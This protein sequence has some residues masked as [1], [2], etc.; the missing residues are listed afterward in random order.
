MQEEVTVGSLLSY[1]T[2]PTSCWL[3]CRYDGKSSSTHL[4]QGG[5]GNGAQTW[6]NIEEKKSLGAVDVVIKATIPGFDGQMC[7]KEKHNSIL[8][9]PLLCCLC[10]PQPLLLPPPGKMLGRKSVNL[11]RSVL[12][13]IDRKK[14]TSSDKRGNTGDDRYDRGEVIWWRLYPV[15]FRCNEKAGQEQCRWPRAWASYSSKWI[16]CDLVRI[17]KTLGLQTKRERQSKG[18]V[19]GKD[20]GKFK[21]YGKHY[22]I[23]R[24]IIIYQALT[25]SREQ[26]SH[27]LSVA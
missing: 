25:L 20:G 14:E 22:C 12:K 23:L 21:K 18:E 9:T 15:I 1:V 3:I 10:Y 7:V 11:I 17:T 4:R 27:S 24:K 13:R 8:F 19:G 26:G 6:Q 5:L 2:L 16:K